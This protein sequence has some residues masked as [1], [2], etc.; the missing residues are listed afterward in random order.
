MPVTTEGYFQRLLSRCNDIG[1][2]A[3]EERDHGE[4]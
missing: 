3:A 4:V 2:Q 1:G